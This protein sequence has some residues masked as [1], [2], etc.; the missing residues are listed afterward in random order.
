[1][2]E[3][4]HGWGPAHAIVACGVLIAAVVVLHRLGVRGDGHTYDGNQDGDD[5]CGD[6]DGD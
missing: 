1:M 3:L 6:G 2:D 4:I 5:G